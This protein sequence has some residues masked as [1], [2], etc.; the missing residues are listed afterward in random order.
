M[1]AL[2]YTSSGFPF[3]PFTKI[4]S[5]DVNQCFFDI[6]T[7]L[8]TTKLDDTNV[9]VH[10][11]TRIG[12]TSRLKTGT[13][14][15]VLINDSSGDMGE[16][17]SVNNGAVYFNAS[18]VATATAGLPLSSGGTGQSLTLGSADQVL[19][20]DPTGTVVQFR[21]APTSPPNK[22]FNFYNLA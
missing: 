14:K 22:L 17:L 10:G 4:L 7:L 21:D 19:A 3:V 20:V 1:P 8:N 5:A 11:L 16:L 18:G 12:A 15:A 2:T 6:R 13:A 9:Q